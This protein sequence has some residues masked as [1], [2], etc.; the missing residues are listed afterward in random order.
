MHIN[1]RNLSG[2]RKARGL[3][4]RQLHEKS[5]VSEKQIQRLEDPKQASKNVRDYT[6]GRLADALGV[7]VE[8]LVGGRQVPDSKVK[9]IRTSLLP[10]VH[11]AYEL[12]ER[13]YRVT[14]GQ[15]VNMAPLFFV[16]LAEG[17]LNWRKSQLK[18]LRQAIEAVEALGDNRRRCAWHVRHA[19]DGCGYEQDAVNKGNLFSDPYPHEYE[20]DPQD[21]WDGSPFADYLRQ[22]AD[23][24][25]KPELVDLKDYPPERVAGFDG[26]P[27]Y[28]VCSGDLSKVV[29][30]G[31]DAAHA[32]HAGD[33]R[34]SD[35][36]ESLRAEDASDGREAWLEG[37]LSQESKEWLDKLAWFRESINLDMGGDENTPKGK[38]RRAGSEA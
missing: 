38:G 13:R 22:L 8:K 10:G 28:S 30:S 18:E 16:L 14:L 15:L 21:D 34:L 5:N 29:S 24:I 31:S 33:A 17:S 25:G 1:P 27:T 23:E 36:P 4:R 9:R 3:S 32:L 37:Q 19:E 35:I 11:L 26:L 6:V 2:L 20:F 12:I 7:T